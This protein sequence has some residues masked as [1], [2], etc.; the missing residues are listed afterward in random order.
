MNK[1]SEQIGLRLRSARRAANFKSARSFAFQNNIPE[2]TYSQHETGKRSLSPEM[3]L[4]YSDLLNIN[5]GWLLTGKGGS[6]I[7]QEQTKEGMISPEIQN[8]KDYLDGSVNTIPPIKDRI[9]LVDMDLFFD[10]LRAI[11][12]TFSNDKIRV[13]YE[14]LL[15]FCIEVY[16]NVVSNSVNEK[17]RKS[18]INL[19]VSSL[20][21]GINKKK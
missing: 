15:E 8:L 4:R 1:L 12:V 11:A 21:R 9:A 7:Y 17:N 3:L 19:S 5:I 13:G 14:E 18:L 6:S 2:S 20:K 10:V 16:N